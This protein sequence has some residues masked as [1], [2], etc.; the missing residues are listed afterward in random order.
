MTRQNN[1]NKNLVVILNPEQ[2]F[3]WQKLHASDSRNWQNET[4]SFPGAQTD[5]GDEISWTFKSKSEKEVQ[6]NNLLLFVNSDDDVQWHLQIWTSEKQLD[7]IALTPKQE[8]V[9]KLNQNIIRM[10]LTAK[11][12]SRKARIFEENVLKNQISMLIAINRSTDVYLNDKGYLN[13]DIPAPSV[14]N[15]KKAFVLL[16]N[17]NNMC[18]YKYNI[19]ANDKNCNEERI[20]RSTVPGLNKG[21]TKTP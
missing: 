1:N 10:K 20:S 13:D 19:Y 2:G 12:P 11:L 3:Q 6:I 16:P 15:K 17:E 9:D 4:T 14:Q 18:V 7:P 8:K 5:V 21:T